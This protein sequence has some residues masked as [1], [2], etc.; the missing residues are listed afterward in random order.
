MN[1][2]IVHALGRSQDQDSQ[3]GLGWNWAIRDSS[4]SGTIDCILIVVATGNLLDLEETTK[5]P[6]STVS[7]NTTNMDEIPRPPALNS[8]N[9][10]WVSDSVA[11]D[12]HGIVFSF[13]SNED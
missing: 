13:S 12:P 6:L 3:E 11:G 10:I 9:V 7:A 8:S 1:L 5:A 4:S 2:G